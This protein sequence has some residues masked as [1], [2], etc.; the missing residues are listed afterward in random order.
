MPVLGVNNASIALETLPLADCDGAK[1]QQ[2]LQT[3]F[4]GIF[5]CMKYEIKQMLKQQGGV[6]VNL[7]SIGGLSGIPYTSTYSATKHAVV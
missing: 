7:A 6:I 2:M 3:N 1:F 4:M 5:W